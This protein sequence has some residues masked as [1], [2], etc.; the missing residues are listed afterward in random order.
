[1][2][3]PVEVMILSEPLSSVDWKLNELLAADRRAREYAQHSGQQEMTEQKPFAPW[4][5]RALNADI[6]DHSQDKVDAEADPLVAEGE[7]EP[8]DQPDDQ[9]HEHFGPEPDFDAMLADARS[10]GE[11]SGYARASE[12][13]AQDRE[14]Q[15]EQIQQL[16]SAIGQAQV[17]LTDYVEFVRELATAIAEHVLRQELLCSS[18]RMRDLVRS[19]V[20]R[21]ASDS[22]AKLEIRANQRTLDSLV[23]AL[24]GLDT[25]PALHRDESLGDGDFHFKMASTEGAEIVADKINSAVTSLFAAAEVPQQRSISDAASE[26]TIDSTTETASES[27]T[28]YAAETRESQPEGQELLPADRNQPHPVSP[29]AGTDNGTTEIDAQW[30]D[31][32]SADTDKGQD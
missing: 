24:A 22:V 19:A 16:V 30:P 11:R 29:D 32:D 3:W 17:D 31:S 20:G 1:M 18:E 27:A 15:R 25:Q 8:A 21:L 12:E 10:A 4:E 7:P 28:E 14:Q 6:A 23:E 5:P 2:C 9:D 26:T 13:L